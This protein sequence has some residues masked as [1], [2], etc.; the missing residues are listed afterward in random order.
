[1]YCIVQLSDTA[2]GSVNFGLLHN[3]QQCVCLPYRYK[4]M[5]PLT[6]YT[7]HHYR[8]MSYHFQCF[9]TM[10]AV[11]LF[12]NYKMLTARCQSYLGV[13]QC[14]PGPHHQ[15]LSTGVSA[16]EVERVSGGRLST[17]HGGYRGSKEVIFHGGVFHTAE[18]KD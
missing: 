5:T 13:A 1:M 15:A 11:G 3:L 4:L 18:M 6:H 2:P 16:R 8:Q 7:S 9:D 12:C 10:A 17:K 14:Q